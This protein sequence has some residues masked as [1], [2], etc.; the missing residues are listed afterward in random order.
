MDRPRRKRASV[1]TGVVVTM[2]YVLFLFPIGCRDGGGPDW[3]CTSPMGTPTFSVE[4]FG[5][6]NTLD[7]IPPILFGLFVGLITWW[8][9]GLV[10]HSPTS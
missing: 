6:D 7:V 9:L 8:L 5:L 4:D 2:G 3:D 1:I 10:R